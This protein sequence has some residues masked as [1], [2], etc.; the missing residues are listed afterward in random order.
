MARARGRGTG[1]PTSTHG[2]PAAAPPARR[3]HRAH[4]ADLRLWLGLALV[5]VSM[6]VGA[7]LL[8][9]D[10]DTVLVL[11]ASR[12]LAVGAPLEGL[13]FVRVSRAAAGG[14]YLDGPAP[15]GVLRWPVAA[16]ELVPRS[17]VAIAPAAQSRLV[18]I[19]VEPLHAP[20]GLQAGDLVD[21]W[22]SPRE[23]DPGQP[24]LVLPGITVSSVSIDDMGMGGEIGVVL[25][26]PVERVPAVVLA[27]RSGVIDLV[28][29]PLASQSSVSGGAAS[30]P[31][32]TG[33]GED[34]T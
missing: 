15:E 24:V 12:D 2:A 20:P 22:S 6:L 26:I 16:G 18:T 10:D 27:A 25:D 8:A 3:M 23:S 31:D 11:R 9:V 28:A 17:A 1:Q 21:V 30:M 4:L 13:T 5:I 34:P 7:R 14:L 32:G 29:V 19:P 33:G